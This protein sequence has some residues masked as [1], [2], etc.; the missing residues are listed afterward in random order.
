M[1]HVYRWAPSPLSH[2][3]KRLFDSRCNSPMNL[4][5]CWTTTL[6]W[7]PHRYRIMSVGFDE[8]NPCQKCWDLSQLAVSVDL[9]FPSACLFKHSQSHPSCR[10]CDL[11]IVQRTGVLVKLA[12]HF[13]KKMSNAADIY[14]N[15]WKQPPQRNAK[16]K[17]KDFRVSVKRVLRSLRSLDCSKSINSVPNIFLK[18]CAIQLATPLTKLFR[19][20]ARN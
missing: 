5:S 16:T 10:G 11:L 20:F 1:L 18:E 9:Y 8:L 2:R 14:D 3:G 17:L 15:D 7:G 4:N 13:T 6:F 19:P 12:F